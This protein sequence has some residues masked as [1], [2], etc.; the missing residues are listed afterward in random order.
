MQTKLTLRLGQGLIVRAKK[1]A[2]KNGRSLSQM[3]A[4]YFET[5]ARH[6]KDEK[7]DKEIALTP[8]VSRLKGSWKGHRV[9]LRDYHKHL[10]E[11]YL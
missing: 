5:L 9:N 11:K 7:S 6:L 10:E 1:Q 3:V 8:L 4:D 2:R